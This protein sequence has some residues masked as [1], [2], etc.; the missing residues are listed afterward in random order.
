MLLELGLTGLLAGALAA[1]APAPGADVDCGA[2]VCIYGAD[3]DNWKPDSRLSKKARRKNAKRNR[4]RK[5]VALSVTVEGARASV[6]VDGRY[7]ASEGPHALRGVKPGKHEIEV[8]DGERVVA[9]G[10]LVIPRKAGAVALVVHDG[11]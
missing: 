3:A 11:R 1:F 2:Q 5:D 6:F 4:K 9:V 8:R 10:V 7:L